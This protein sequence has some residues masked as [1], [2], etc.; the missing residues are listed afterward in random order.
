MITNTLSH[1]INLSIIQGIVPDELKLAR[2]IPL[3]KKNIKT[4]VGNYRPLSTLSVISKVLE[5]VVY[6]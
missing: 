3:F 6:D 4:E 1:I 5:R 2:V